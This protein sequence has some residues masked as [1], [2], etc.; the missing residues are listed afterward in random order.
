M[1]RELQITS[2]MIE[3]GKEIL[4]QVDDSRRWISS[5]E[6]VKQIFRAMLLTS[7]LFSAQPPEVPLNPRS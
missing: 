2:E 7:P 1:D 3:A 6:A 4:F 5:D